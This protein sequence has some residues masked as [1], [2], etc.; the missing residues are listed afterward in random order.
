MNIVV[1]LSNTGMIYT[2]FVQGSI[3]NVVICYWCNWFICPIILETVVSPFYS[4]AQWVAHQWGVLRS[5]NKPAAVGLASYLRPLLIGY[6]TNLT[7]SY[8]WSRT[9]SLPSLDCI[10]CFKVENRMDNILVI[11]VK[12]SVS[13]IL[14]TFYDKFGIHC[15]AYCSLHNVPT[16]SWNRFFTICSIIFRHNRGSNPF[17]KPYP[18]TLQL[19]SHLQIFISIHINQIFSIQYRD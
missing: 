1:W 13:V 17:H 2:A 6:I 8:V 14:T 19:Q 10:H 12:V 5:N 3:M 18:D 4:A 7:I 9:Y 16:I 15:I 11:A